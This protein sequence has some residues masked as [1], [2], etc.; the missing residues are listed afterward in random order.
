MAKVLIIE[1]EEALRTV[2]C[3]I[4]KTAGYKVS[5]AS[6]G[7]EGLEQLASFLPDLILL[8]ML[9]PVKSGLEFLQEAYITRDYPKTTVI[10]L[11]N[12]SDSPTIQEA[13]KLGAARH[14]IKANTLPND[15]LAVVKE[16]CA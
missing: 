9:M 3:M 2:Y 10:I 7:Q 14:L 15:L 1:D 6:D 12:L 13:L 8:D 16:H 11:S 4:L 5:Q